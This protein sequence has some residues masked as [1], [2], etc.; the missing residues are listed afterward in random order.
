MSRYLFSPD[1]PIQL[2]TGPYVFWENGFSDEDIENII[3]LGKH[4]NPLQAQVQGGRVV[5]DIRISNIS[6]IDLQEDSEWLYDRIA[7]I[8]KTL[9]FQYYKFDLSGFYEHMQ[10]TIYEGNEL[11]HY[12]WHLD[13][14]AENVP[15]RKLSFVLQLSDAEDYEGGD[16][17]I[18]NSVNPVTIKK[19]K[20]FGVLFPSYTLHRVTPITK[21]V[22]KTLVVWV[23]GPA[24]R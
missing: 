14:G 12:D 3:A 6:W 16:L 21:G 8:I 24:F 1:P 18:M 22:R 7:Y 5:K 23:T 20:G 4:R 10:F 11:G 17:Q 9:N 15:P 13:I 2:K 19:E